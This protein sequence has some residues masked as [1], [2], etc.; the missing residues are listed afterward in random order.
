[1]LAA[2]NICR[3]RGTGG[4]DFSPVMNLWLQRCQ[5]R[6]LI[7][8]MSKVKRIVKTWIIREEEKSDIYHP[9]ESSLEEVDRGYKLF[10]DKVED[11]HPYKK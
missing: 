1:M 10:L 9:L 11:L 2:E 8:R 4:I 6:K 5:T 3:K 7:R